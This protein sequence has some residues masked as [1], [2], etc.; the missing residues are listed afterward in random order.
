MYTHFKYFSFSRIM[1]RCKW[2]NYIPRLV[3]TLN[4]DDPD[5]R[6]EYCEWYLEQCNENARFPTEIVWSDEATSN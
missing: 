1:K 2:K 3:H 4:D 5:R 6:V